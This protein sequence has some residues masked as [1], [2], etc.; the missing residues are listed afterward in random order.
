[1]ENF[2][3]ALSRIASA[4]G[5]SRYGED[6]RVDRHG[7]FEVALR[8]KEPRRRVF[9][10]FRVL[11]CLTLDGLHFFLR[12][13][14]ARKI[15]GSRRGLRGWRSWRPRENNRAFRLRTARRESEQGEKENETQ[16]NVAHGVSHT[17]ISF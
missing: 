6:D 16:V 1:M 10:R 9:A 15:I 13:K 8:N 5:L 3:P 17:Q 12:Q 14:H 4:V 2:P 7:R 11:E